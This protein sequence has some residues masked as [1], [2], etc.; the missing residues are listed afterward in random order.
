M[1]SF[2][3]REIWFGAPIVLWLALTRL[4]E[5]A[6]VESAIARLPYWVSV[7]VTLCGVASY[8]VAKVMDIY[9]LPT[10]GR[11]E[12]TLLALALLATPFAIHCTRIPTPAFAWLGWV[13]LPVWLGLNLWAATRV[14]AKAEAEEET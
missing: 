2:L 12:T 1:R 9:S 10:K 5:L 6:F 11:L 14:A 7:V 13:F 3:P 8:S 4:S